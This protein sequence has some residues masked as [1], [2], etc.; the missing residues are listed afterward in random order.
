[1]N[2]I[3]DGCRRGHHVAANIA[4][5]RQRRHQ[6]FVDLFDRFAEV[7]FQ[8][9][10]KLD[11][12]TRRNADRAVGKL[13]GH[14]IQIEILLIGNLTGR[15]CNAEHVAVGFAQS[16]GPPRFSQVSIILLVGPVKLQQLQVVFFETVFRRVGQRFVNRTAQKLAVGFRDFDFGRFVF[17]FGHGASVFGV[18]V[19]FQV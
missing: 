2:R 8:D 5:G 3:V 7:A 19:R 12:L 10:V 9:T 14:P 18:S 17:I 11:G 13:V 6:R 15:Q 16:F 4:A 1:M